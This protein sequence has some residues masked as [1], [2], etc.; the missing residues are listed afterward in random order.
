MLQLDSQRAM[1][2]LSIEKIEE[3]FTMTRLFVSRIKS[4]MKVVVQRCGQLETSQS[5][6]SKKLEE[7]EKEL[8]EAKLLV[9]QVSFFSSHVSI[10]TQLD[11]GLFNIY[12]PISIML[13]MSL[14]KRLGSLSNILNTE[15]H[16]V[17][18]RK[19]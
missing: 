11:V 15:F 13:D 2:G 3:E 19:F 16:L 10:S 12:G 18:F 7:R 4:E 1:S 9:Q 17:S 6:V 14:F 8:S 5:N